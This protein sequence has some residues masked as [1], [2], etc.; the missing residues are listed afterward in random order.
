M[1][2]KRRKQN[3]AQGKLGLGCCLMKVIGDPEE[4]L[5]LSRALGIVMN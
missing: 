3:W 1:E 2:W 4:Y 5:R